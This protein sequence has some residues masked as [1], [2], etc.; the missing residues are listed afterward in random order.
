MIINNKKIKQIPVN[1][2]INNQKINNSKK[3]KKIAA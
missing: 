3:K 2:R 1:N